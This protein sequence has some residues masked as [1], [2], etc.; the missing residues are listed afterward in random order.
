VYPT[1]ILLNWLSLNGSSPQV[2]I[3][4]ILYLPSQKYLLH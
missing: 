1:T 2:P 3:V 4:A